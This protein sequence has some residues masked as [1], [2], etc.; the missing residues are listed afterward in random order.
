MASISSLLKQRA[1]IKGK[2]DSYLF[3]EFKPTGDLDEY[4]KTKRCGRV[5]LAILNP[6]TVPDSMEDR[7][8]RTHFKTITVPGSGIRMTSSINKT[9]PSVDPLIGYRFGCKNDRKNDHER[10]HERD[11]DSSL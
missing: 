5:D 10:C 3:L 8:P 2:N 11:Y 1:N 6:A 9:V 7:D 4:F